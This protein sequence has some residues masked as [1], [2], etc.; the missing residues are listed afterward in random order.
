MGTFIVLS[1]AKDKLVFYKCFACN[2]TSLPKEIKCWIS[3]YTFQ[4]PVLP[5]SRKKAGSLRPFLCDF[6]VVFSYCPYLLSYISLRSLS[7]NSRSS[8]S[9][10]GKFLLWAITSSMVSMGIAGL[11]IRLISRWGKE[12]RVVTFSCCLSNRSKSFNATL[13]SCASNAPWHTSSAWFCLAPL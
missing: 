8:G 6:L 5:V 13:V 1:L 12:S 10:W 11:W 2:L 7:D 9:G 4:T 3:A